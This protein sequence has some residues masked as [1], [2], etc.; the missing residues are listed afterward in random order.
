MRD[1]RLR[2]LVT[3][4]NPWVSIAT[5]VRWTA[6][7]TTPNGSFWDDSKLKKWR[8]SNDILL[9]SS[10]IKMEDLDGTHKVELLSMNRLEYN[11]SSN[12]MVVES[13]SHRRTVWSNINRNFFPSLQ[14]PPF[15]HCYFSY[16]LWGLKRNLK[17]LDDIWKHVFS[18]LML[19]K[20][21]QI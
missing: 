5:P 4:V 12:R 6:H 14:L 9:K 1:S 17:S 8:S 7:K 15:M 3:K 19:V 10:R 21:C 2:P 13:L 18:D 16:N 11:E 20:C